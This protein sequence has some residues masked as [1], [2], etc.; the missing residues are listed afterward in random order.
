MDL[1]A[2][3]EA[4]HVRHVLVACGDG[5]QAVQPHMHRV[6][7]GRPETVLALQWAAP[8]RRRVVVVEHD[9]QPRRGQRVHRAVE[10]AEGRQVA[11][12]PAQAV[13]ACDCHG[14]D[15]R[16]AKIQLERER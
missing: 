11:G 2:Y 12:D 9:E 14:V 8:A 10:Q 5:R 16:V 13:V 7:V 4:H 1:V 3:V 6:V 15:E